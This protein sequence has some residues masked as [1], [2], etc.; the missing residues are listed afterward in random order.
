MMND[1]Y[2]ILL[3]IIRKCCCVNWS[4]PLLF[5]KYLRT[6]MYDTIALQAELVLLPTTM[7]AIT[8]QGLS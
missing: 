5:N 2:G 1:G 4:R 7:Q 8:K 3:A 6:I